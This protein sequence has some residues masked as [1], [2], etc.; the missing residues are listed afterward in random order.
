M[1]GETLDL[2]GTALDSLLRCR[3]HGAVVLRHE[4]TIQFLHII[5]GS[6]EW[7]DA[8]PKLAH[9]STEGPDGLLWPVWSFPTTKVDINALS[10]RAKPLTDEDFSPNIQ[11]TDDLEEDHLAR[12]PLSITNSSRTDPE[13]REAMMK[14]G[15]PF[16]PRRIYFPRAEAMAH[17]MVFTHNYV[18][19]KKKDDSI[20]NYGLR[21]TIVIHFDVLAAYEHGL[22]HRVAVDDSDPDT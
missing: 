18:R 7:R 22:L 10:L 17:I 20:R 13:M 1:K 4:F 6:P 9:Y 19:R 3:D 12:L 14:V 11:Y 5:G 15:R 16:R 21:G 8:S 2:C